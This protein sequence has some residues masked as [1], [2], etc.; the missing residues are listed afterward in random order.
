M[1]E[2]SVNFPDRRQFCGVSA[3]ITTSTFMSQV[4][5]QNPATSTPT[6][7]GQEMPTLIHAPRLPPE[8]RLGW[9]LVGLGDFSITQLIPAFSQCQRSKLVALVT[10]N[11]EKG[12]TLARQTGIPERSVYDYSTFNR[13]ADDPRIDVVYIVLP[14][15][16]HAEYTVRAAQAGK[17]V[18]CEKPMANSVEECRAMMQACEKAGK[19]LMIAYR[20]QFETYNRAAI[21][22]LRKRELGTLVSIVADHGRILNPKQLRDQWRMRRTLAGGGSLVDIGIYSLQAARYLCGEEPV[23]VTAMLHSPPNDQRF[24]EVEETV[25]FQLR[26]PSGVIANCSSSYGWCQVKRVRAIASDGWIDLDPATAYSGNR[27]RIGRGNEQNG[28]TEE[29]QL[30][31]NNQFVAEIDHFSE[32]ISNRQ[33]PRTPGEEGLRD[34]RLIQ[35]IYESARVGR[36]L[37]ANR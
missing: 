31:E 1:P 4:T 37:R 6:A 5:A 28:R 13:I 29:R 30:Q 19:K 35:L 36:T 25:H 11:A 8:S 12:R 22:M 23:E 20:A 15:G 3:A 21:D 32:C 2:R 9:A 14:N 24:R 7:Q 10:G 34:V 27:M 17:H 26:F 18:M 16:L 33:T